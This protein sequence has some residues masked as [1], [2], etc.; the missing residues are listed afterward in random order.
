MKHTLFKGKVDPNQ[1]KHVLCNYP[2]II[3]TFANNSMRI[4]KQIAWETQP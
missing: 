4:L 3:N 1:I 2:K